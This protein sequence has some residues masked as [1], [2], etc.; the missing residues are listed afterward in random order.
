MTFEVFMLLLLAFSV[1]TSLFVEA[2]KMLLDSLKVEYAS[3]ILV[4]C[5][6]IVVGG[7]G[8]AFFYTWNDIAFTVKNIISIILMVCANWL[9]AMLGYD[10]VVQAIAQLRGGNKDE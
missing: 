1:F 2:W 4:L 9:V 5:M 3:N 7:I 10:K 6:A 8:T